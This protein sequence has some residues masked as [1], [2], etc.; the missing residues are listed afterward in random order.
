[1]VI[2]YG[3][4]ECPYCAAEIPKLAGV[5]LVFRH[6]PVVSKHPKSRRLA[7]AAPLAALIEREL[8]PGPA[9]DTDAQLLQDF[10][11]RAGTVFRRQ[12]AHDRVRFPEDEIV[13]FERRH[14]AI[15]IHRQISGLVVLAE[16]AADIDALVRNGWIQT[17]ILF[18]QK[19]VRQHPG[20]IGSKRQVP[21]KI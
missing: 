21:D 11:E 14:E 3:D 1:M 18:Q 5:T 2:V 12:I 6:F 16:R 13:L 20:Q 10:R 15:R 4:Y 7:A 17:T 9:K 19:P 8:L